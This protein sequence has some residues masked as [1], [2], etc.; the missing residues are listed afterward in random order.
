MSDDNCYICLDTEGVLTKF[1]DNPK[2]S[3]KAHDD[4]FEQQSYRHKMNCVVC[5][6]S[7]EY[8]FST[9]KCEGIERF[10]AYVLLFTVVSIISFPIYFISTHLAT[11]DESGS[12]WFVSFFSVMVASMI[13]LFLSA[14]I[15][16]PIMIIL[17]K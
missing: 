10:V 8:R 11:C 4:C 1:C 6:N 17:R 15:A 5:T 7:M 12:K 16:L 2:C 9:E 13:I 3:I 14:W